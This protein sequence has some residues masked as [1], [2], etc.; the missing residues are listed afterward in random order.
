MG[1]AKHQSNTSSREKKKRNVFFTIDFIYFNNKEYWHLRM[2]TIQ[3]KKKKNPS[4]FSIV[5]IPSL[6]LPRSH[7]NTFHSLFSLKHAFI[8]SKKMRHSIRLI[9]I[10]IWLLNPGVFISILYVFFFF[11]P[12]FLCSVC[13]M[14]SNI[15]ITSIF[16]LQIKLVYLLQRKVN[17]EK[18]LER[19]SEYI[20]VYYYAIWGVMFSIYWISSVSLCAL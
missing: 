8:Q 17:A 6:D 2:F 7:R 10:Y 4:N 12:M 1:A 19:K 13:Q 3:Q 20:T 14:H 5:K 18:D 16:S 9:S 11:I 15:S